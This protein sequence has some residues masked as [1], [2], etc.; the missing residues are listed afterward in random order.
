MILFDFEDDKFVLETEHDFQGTDFVY[1]DDPVEHYS[2]VGISK[3]IGSFE[4]LMYLA[5]VFLYL[6]PDVDYQIYTGY[7]SWLGSR[8]SGMSI[9]TYGK[10]RIDHFLRK[11]FFTRKKPYCKRHRRVIFNRNK[12]I[13]PEDKLSITAQLIRRGC[14]FTDLDI[15]L[16]LP[17]LHDKLI[18]CTSESI[19]SYLNCSTS[20][21]NRLLTPGIKKTM[22]KFNEM[23]RKE[24]KMRILLENIQLLTSN[25]EPIKVRALKELSSI[26]D[27]SLIKKAISTFLDDESSSS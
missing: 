14:R 16:S 3:K 22:K 13:S 25:G 5:E 19:A 17:T 7:F 12:I 15:K 27:Y 21:V 4:E 10:A 6:N 24:Q 18:V 1:Y 2:L 8:D 20:T 23:T 26:R 9:R 11:I